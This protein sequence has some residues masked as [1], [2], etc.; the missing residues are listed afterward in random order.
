[1][2]APDDWFSELEWHYATEDEK[3]AVM[4]AKDERR[5]VLI[6]IVGG[7]DGFSIHYEDGSRSLGDLTDAQY[8]AEQRML[9]WDISAAVG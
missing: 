3:P 4:W 7:G 6:K 2:K 9:S 8:E 5:D 1:M